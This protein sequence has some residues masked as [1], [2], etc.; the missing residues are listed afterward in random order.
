[1]GERYDALVTVGSSGSFPLVA[2]AEGKGA[3]SMALLRSGPGEAPMPDVR[4]AELDGRLLSLGDLRAAPEVA[5][6]PAEPDRT[7]RVPLEGQMATYQWM[8]EE[9]LPLELRQGERVRL[10]LDNRSMMWHPMHL[11]GHTFQVQG[12]SGPGPRKDTVIVPAM[13]R[14][15]I[16]VVADNPGQWALHCHNVYHAEAGMQTVLSYAR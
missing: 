2:V 15:V 4:P 9:S 5:F 10:V 12:P 16:D 13:Q 11:H 8:I 1:M 7:Y 6:P 14:V 3:Q